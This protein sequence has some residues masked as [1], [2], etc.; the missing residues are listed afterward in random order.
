MSGGSAFFILIPAMYLLFAVALGIIALVDRRLVAARWASLGFAVACVSISIDGY[1]DPGGDH[2]VSWLSVA[3]H[4]IPLLVMV[5]A[6][7]T[8]HGRNAPRWAV[9]FTIFACLFTMPEMFW[10]PPA[11]YRGVFVQAACATI[12]ASG[13]P[14]LWALRRGARVDQIAFAVVL[15]AALSYTGRMIAIGLHPIGE[16]QTEMMAFYEGLNIVFHSASALMGMSVGIVLMMMIG[17]DMLLG[18][19]KDSEVDTLTMLG[20]RRRLDSRIA[21]DAEGK[22]PVGAVVVI[23][24]DRFKQINDRFGH[25][26]G[27]EVLR[28]VG[29]KLAELYADIG[30][31]CRTGGEEFVVLI[32]AANSASASSLAIMTRLAIAELAFDGGMAQTR[33]TAS[34]GF[35]ERDYDESVEDSI[36][37][38]DQAVYCAKTNGRDQVV[39]AINAKGLHVLKAVA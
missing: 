16:T 11:W 15:A 13:L 10:A 12:I 28:A 31:P 21:E 36:R 5:Q 30:C 25:D 23:D 9:A 22:H 38:A 34:V 24:L 27:D 6:F 3:T 35:H 39:G 37:R 20:N 32:D 14:P 1:R 8:R 4:F 26:A 2:W 7:L 19:M 17:H 29:K 33:I 18:R